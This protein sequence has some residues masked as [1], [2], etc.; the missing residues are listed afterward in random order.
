MVKPY[1]VDRGLFKN[2]KCNAQQLKKDEHKQ[3]TRRPPS[4]PHNHNHNHNRPHAYKT[5]PSPLLLSVSH[6]P[7][8]QSLN[9]ALSL[10]V[11]ILIRSAKP[12]HSLQLRFAFSVCFLSA[13]LAGWA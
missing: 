13:N 5:L 9:I 2:P 3:S 4:P 6:T 11:P 7:D 1:I 12:A 8:S 10:S